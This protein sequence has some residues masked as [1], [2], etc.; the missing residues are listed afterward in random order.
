MGICL[1]GGND[2]AVSFGENISTD[3][4]N[5]DGEK[6]YAGAPKSI[7]RRKTV[8]VKS[9]PPNQWGLYEMHGNVWEWCQD[10]YGEYPTTPTVDPV[11]PKIGTTRVMRGGSWF[12]GARG[13]RSANRSGDVRST[14]N[15]QTG[16]RF[17]IV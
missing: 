3:Q 15:D 17:I 5:Y 14:S 1:Q 6:P 7:F 2:H 11:G 12:R 10:L 13:V 16:F 4:V 9:L 8:A